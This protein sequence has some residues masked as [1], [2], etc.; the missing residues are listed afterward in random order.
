MKLLDD[1][2]LKMIDNI[3]LYKNNQFL[4]LGYTYDHF[5][6]LSEFR[7]LTQFQKE[8]VIY[9]AFVAEEP[10][11]NKMKSKLMNYDIKELPQNITIG[12]PYK[13]YRSP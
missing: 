6:P 7:K 9:K 10:I 13:R 1:Q 5:I 2:P 12:Y 11:D 8:Q 4:P 3:I